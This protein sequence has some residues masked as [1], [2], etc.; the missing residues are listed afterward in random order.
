M[1]QSMSVEVVK[2]FHGHSNACRGFLMRYLTDCEISHENLMRYL[3]DCEISH[4]NLMRY[5]TRRDYYGTPSNNAR[6]LERHE[7]F[8]QISD[9][10]L[11]LESCFEMRRVRVPSI[12]VLQSV[13]WLVRYLMR[14]S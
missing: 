11:V 6:I 14:F 2:T 8:S 13:P 10:V 3:T 7:F 12:N 1:S 4:E 5:L 9:E